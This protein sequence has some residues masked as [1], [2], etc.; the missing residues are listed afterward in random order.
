[1]KANSPPGAGQAF[2][3]APAS[4]WMG[5]ALKVSSELVDVGTN[6]PMDR[7]VSLTVAL[8]G[9]RRLI[10]PD[11]LMALSPLNPRMLWCCISVQYTGVIEYLRGRSETRTTLG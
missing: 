2:F 7:A 9:A 3:R 10:S 8:L 4:Y 11:R 1:V 5:A 6:Q